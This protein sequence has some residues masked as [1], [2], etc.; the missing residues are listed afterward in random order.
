MIDFIIRNKYLSLFTPIIVIVLLSIGVKN[1]GFT[2]DYHMFFSSDNP[3]LIAFDNLQDTYNKTD[4]VLIGLRDTKGIFTKQNLQAIAQITTR[5]WQMPFSTR[6]DSLSNY[7]HTFA[8]GDDLSVIDLI[9]TEE[10][11]K[12]KQIEAIATNEILLKNKLVTDKKDTTGIN[13]T[14]QLPN[15]EKLATTAQ[16]QVVAFARA[17][18][19]TIKKDYP[20][21]EV[22][23]SGIIMLNQA[24]PEAGENDI[25]NLVPISFLMVFV[26]LFVVLRNIVLVLG[27]LILLVLTIVS[28]FGSA[29]YLGLPITPP[30]TSMPVIILTIA[31]AG[32]VHLMI[33]FVKKMRSGMDKVLAVKE[34]FNHN[35][36]AITIAGLTTAIGFFG[37]N[38]SEVPPFHDLGN[39]A[40]IG[41]L[42]SLMLILVFLPAWMLVM[43]I[44]IKEK[45]P[46]KVTLM[47][48]F[49]HF[50]TTQYKKILVFSVLFVV[51]FI[52][53][54]LLHEINDNFVEYFD[55]RV[56]FRRDA[57]KVDEHLTGIGSIDYSFESGE[58]GGISNPEFLKD[59][60]KF[61]H[62]ARAQKEVNNVS[63]ITDIFKRLNKNMH[64]DNNVF[65][66]LPEN[67]ELS[68]QY[69]LLYE[70][71]LP[72]GLDLNNQINIDK[73]A[74]RVSVNMKNMSSKGY[75]GF[76]KRASDWLKNNT[77]RIHTE[78]ASP[79]I[80]FAHIGVRNVQAMLIGTSITLIVISII[81]G[82]TLGSFKMGLI[83]LVPNLVPASMAFGL[84]GLTNGQI[85]MALSVVASIT[86]GIIVDDTVH[87]LDK[88][89]HGFKTLGKNAKES[90]LYAFEHVGNALV[91]SSIALTFGFLVLVVS[92]FEI[93]SGMGHLT[94]YVIMIA[95]IMDF[96]L[97]PSLLI[98]FNRSK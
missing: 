43:P 66:Q 2:N 54:I 65:Y 79:S 23:L 3:Q 29:G 83:S 37:L 64:G 74:V 56:E 40:G 81:L 20:Q 92:V 51:I 60:E 73:S 22:F 58:S 41:T 82:F 13:I 76:E 87:F 39:V 25:K 90:V 97:L 7:Q 77:P 21:F 80:M 19:D 49:A 17:L 69:L 50:V 33:S 8:D 96:L 75:L 78:G 86:L 15:D 46:K 63:T 18:R 47:T 4:S 12:P 26:L 6:V 35:V 61:T 84:W 42:L 16:T 48:S 55:E 94:S 72:Y 10:A 67:R 44:K 98:F 68:A 14:I 52:S 32:S 34:A 11:L 85:T 59:V 88:F 28:A 62:W 30:M 57:D 38:F 53:F 27:S 71:S 91:L 5:A 93:N 70:M 45:E 9:D 36:R 24:F 95:L 31:V 89:N 1:L